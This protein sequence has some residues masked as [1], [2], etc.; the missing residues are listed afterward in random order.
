MAD[1]FEEFREA[2]LGDEN[3]IVNLNIYSLVVDSVKHTDVLRCCD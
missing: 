3:I 2:D 1:I